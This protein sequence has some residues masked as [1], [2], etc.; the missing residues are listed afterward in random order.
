MS[1]SVTCTKCGTR[2]D[3][4]WIR[5]LRRGQPFVCPECG[6]SLVETGYVEVMGDDAGAHEHG[7]AG[8]SAGSGRAA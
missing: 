3:A 2:L 7:A 4:G 8:T 1:I 6:R 5:S